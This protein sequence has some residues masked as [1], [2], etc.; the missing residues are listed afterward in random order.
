[1]THGQ[2]TNSLLRLSG[3]VVDKEKDTYLGWSWAKESAAM[4]CRVSS[5]DSRSLNHNTHVTMEQ[6]HALLQDKAIR[7]GGERGRGCGE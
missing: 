2:L 7:I 3:L 4:F 5:S 1:M 6:I